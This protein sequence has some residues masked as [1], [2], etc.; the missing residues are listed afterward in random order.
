MSS[1]DL[2][3]ADNGTYYLHWSEG[4]R[5]KR[6]S[7]RTK[8]V[9]EAKRFLA[10][11]LRLETSAPEAG[12]DLTCGE[13]WALYAEGRLPE[14]M[15]DTRIGAESC[16]KR[17]APVF[18]AIPVAD[19]KQDDFRRYCASRPDCTSG[20]N[21]RDLSTMTASWRW[22]AKAGLMSL[23]LIPSLTLPKA[24]A[25]RTQWLTVEQVE[26]LL[27]AAR[28][29]SASPRMSRV[30]RF[31]WLAFST[32]ARKTAIYELTWDRVDFELGSIDFNKPGRQVTRKR[33]AVVPISESL[34][35]VLERMHAERIND[36]VMDNGFEIYAELRKLGASIGLKVHPH[37]FRHTAATLMLRSGARL[38]Q[39]AGILADTMATVEKNY[40]K[41]C[42]DDLRGATDLLGAS[43]GAAPKMGVISGRQQ[44]TTPDKSRSETAES[45]VRR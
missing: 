43:L 30:E 35:P 31:L 10:E 34:R 5:S 19:V 38:W 18:A 26:Q 15:P 40:G 27:A 20:S 32:G 39:V 6:V 7:T 28:A 1:F 37:L 11:W 12:G 33:R 3:Q 21:R 36:L 4:R 17:L 8:D 29:A 25:P 22:C 23:E 16:W 45:A 2:R 42:L 9:A 41:H 44:P 24:N 14:V 13:A